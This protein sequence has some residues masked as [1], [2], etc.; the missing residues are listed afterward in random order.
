MY[1]LLLNKKSLENP[2]SE[3]N[4]LCCKNY[5]VTLTSF[6][7]LR[8]YKKISSFDFIDLVNSDNFDTCLAQNIIF[9]EKKIPKEYYLTLKRKR[10]GSCIFLGKD[11]LCTIYKERPMVCRLYPFKFENGEILAKEQ[12]RCQHNWQLSS[13]MKKNLFKIKEQQQKELKLFGILARKWNSAFSKEGNL[14]SFLEF[15]FSEKI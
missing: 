7:I 4:A 2:C 13:E 14:S 8:I 15:I 9:F 3:C 6:D 12:I 5:A 1:G 10:N 11:N